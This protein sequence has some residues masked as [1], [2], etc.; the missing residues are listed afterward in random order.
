MANRHRR[1]SSGREVAGLTPA[2]QRRV[3]ENWN[4]T[5]REIPE[6]T[7]P[8]LFEAQA[9]RTPDATAVVFGNVSLSYADW[10]SGRTG[11]RGT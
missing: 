2:E 6:V 5:A 8:E 1:G 11:W 4:D 10:T 3:L 7:L 9:A